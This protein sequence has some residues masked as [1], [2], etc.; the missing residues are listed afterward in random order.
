MTGGVGEWRVREDPTSGGG[1]P[2]QVLIC[3]DSEVLR[4][5][6]RTVLRAA[7]D[8]A[9]VAEAADGGRHWLSP[10][11]IDPTSPWSASA[12]WGRSSRISSGP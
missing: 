11:S 8:L 4:H 5:G 6:L 9:V 2:I 12:R 3:D 10:P 1:E 7:P